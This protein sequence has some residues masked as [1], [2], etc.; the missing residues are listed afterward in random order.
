MLA[1]SIA[2]AASLGPAWILAFGQSSSRAAA[3][4]L[5]TGAPLALMAVLFLFLP[6]SATLL[7]LSGKH[8]ASQEPVAPAQ[9]RAARKHPPQ[10]GRSGVALRPAAATAF[11]LAGA[12]GVWLGF[13]PQ[14]SAAE[15]LEFYGD[16]KDYQRVLSLARQLHRLQPEAEVRL[17][18]ALYHAGQL[19]ENLF[20][21]RNQ[22]VWEVFPSLGYGLSACR[23]QAQMHLELGQLGEAEHFAHEALEWEGDRPDVL[24][25][26]AQV[27]ILK[28]RP[29]AARVFLN[30]LAQVPFQGAWARQWLKKLADYPVWRGDDSLAD[31]T[32]RLVKTD[33]PHNDVAAAPLLRQLLHSNPRNQMAFEYLMAH[34]LLSLDLDRFA[35]HLKDLD[36]FGYVRIPRHYEEAILLFQKLRQSSVDLSR[37]IRPETQARFQR[38]SEA[39]DRGALR[40]PEGRLRLEPEFGDTFWYYYFAQQQANRTQPNAG[41]AK[42][43]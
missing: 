40:T 19:G 41:P 20:T 10:S 22:T 28:D 26:L 7:A 8:P 13:D 4:S 18:L 6:L 24:K 16:K 38:F 43:E 23:P 25:L 3:V 2:V 27:N 37:R 31:L 5:G 32:T 9:R 11:V 1:A 29:Q 12:A 15:R 33:M 35:E 36:E 30:V 21:F 17:H 14:R 42:Y 34:Y 39:M